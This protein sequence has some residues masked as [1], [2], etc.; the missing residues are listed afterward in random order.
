MP[1]KQK[2]TAVLK[3][4]PPPEPVAMNIT[5]DRAQWERLDRYS[6][7]IERAGGRR[8][9][10]DELIDKM[11]EKVFGLDRA[12][13]RNE[14]SIRKRKQSAKE[15]PVDTAP[16]DAVKAAVKEDSLSA[17]QGDERSREGNAPGAR[18]GNECG[19]PTPTGSPEPPL[20]R[21]SGA[22]PPQPSLGGQATRSHVALPASAPRPLLEP[23]IDN[24]NS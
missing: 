12:F 6:E 9:S 17:L 10:R 1:A 24:R 8:P 21:S 7:F 23:K 13:R 3:F 19:V 22:M 16:S 5:L 15:K 14:G 11:L 18:S 4:A 20:L 2:E